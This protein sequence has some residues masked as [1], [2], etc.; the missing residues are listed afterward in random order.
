MITLIKKDIL[1]KF[2]H[3]YSDKHVYIT[4]DGAMYSDVYDPVE[5]IDDRIYEETDIPIDDENS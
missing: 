1:G 5:F 3:V 4:R 2:A